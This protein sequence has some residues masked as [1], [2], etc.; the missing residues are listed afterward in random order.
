MGSRAPPPSI[1]DILLQIE[2]WRRKEDKCDEKSKR[3]QYA[4]KKAF[5][6][7]Y[8][9]KFPWLVEVKHE[10]ETVGLLCSVCRENYGSPESKAQCARSG[11]KW[12]S[13]PF[14]KFGDV[15]RRQ[16]MNTNLGQL[17]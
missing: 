1:D 13:V 12:I 4:Q 6:P 14:V 16:R 9:T 15:S 5:D 8:K 10:G 7:Q 17:S 2:T 11:G 3:R